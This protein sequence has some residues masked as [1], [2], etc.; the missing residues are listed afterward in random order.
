MLVTFIEK[1]IKLLLRM[2]YSIQIS[3]LS[4]IRSERKH[5][6]LFVPNHPALIDPLIIYTALWSKFRPRPLIE[7]SQLRYPG[8]K[9]MVGQLKGVLIPDVL[10]G[11]TQVRETVNKTLEQVI[12]A[13][14]EG[15]NVILYPAGRTYRSKHEEL[16]GTSAVHTILQ[17]I[18]DLEV[19]M[20]RTRGLWGS[21]FS[22]AD[23]LLTAIDFKFI[24]RAIFVWFING[25]FFIPKRK[26]EITVKKP[27]DLPREASRQDLNSYLEEFY[28]D[29]TLPNTIVAKYF[30]K[31]NKPIVK[32]EPGKRGGALTAKE[33]NDATKELVLN[34]LKQELGVS[35][36]K[37]ADRLAADLGMD[38]LA[39]AELVTW[40]ESEFGFASGDPDSVITVADVMLAASGNTVGNTEIM[41]KEV[42]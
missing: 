23:G 5:G 1:I 10:S 25:I 34:H 12:K 4:E 15:E 40:I 13:L 38:S 32:P 9:F 22:R 41:L 28:N 8:M 14:K 27:S 36:I 16:R 37:E 18:P 19:V 35:K 7:E 29:N 21:T 20:I 42:P 31:G 39:R 33:V 26:V 24:L 30:W 2:R 17:E 6:M 11:G 3:G